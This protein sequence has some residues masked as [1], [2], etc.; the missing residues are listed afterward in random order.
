MTKA[1]DLIDTLRLEPHP[2]GGWYRQTWRG[3]DNGSGRPT[4]TLIHFLLEAGQASHWHTVDASEIWCWHAG[5]AVRLSIAPGDAGPVTTTM[6]GPDVLAGQAVQQVVPK[7][8][9]QAAA[10]DPQGAQGFAL[11]SCVVAPGFDF[12]GFVLAPPGWAPGA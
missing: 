7:G 4:A 1:R 6:L 10:P 8:H 12:S 5:D 3:P 9:W 11:V 2:E